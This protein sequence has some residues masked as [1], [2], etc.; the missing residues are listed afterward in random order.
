MVAIAVGTLVALATNVLLLF[1]EWMTVA[2]IGTD[3]L[4][5]VAQ[6]VWLLV[7]LSSLVLIPVPLLFHLASTRVF[8]RELKAWL[9]GCGMIILTTLVMFSVVNPRSM[10]VKMRMSKLQVIAQRSAPLI[11]AIERYEEA[12]GALPENL[13]Q[14]IPDY[15]SAIPETGMG[16]SPL[17]KYNDF[18]AP[19]RASQRTSH[20]G[21]SWIL[22]VN[23][24]D[25]LSQDDAFLYY[26]NQRY[27]VAGPGLYL[28][29]VEGWAYQ[30]LEEDL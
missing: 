13:R 30:E 28:G 6:T 20:G 24:P 9:I 17:F 5:M 18:S 4:L 14:L 19:S 16:A 7:M 3:L 2:P 27:E 1:G 29:E 23:V 15:L 22:H 26:P 11:D 21:N 12:K 25:G 8:H 10:G